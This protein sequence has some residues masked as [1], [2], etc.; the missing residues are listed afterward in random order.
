MAWNRANLRC[1]TYFD[2]LWSTPCFVRMPIAFF[3]FECPFVSVCIR[4]MFVCVHL[5]AQRCVRSCMHEK[6]CA[7]KIC[8]KWFQANT[9]AHVWLRWNS[10]KAFYKRI[11]KYSLVY[12]RVCAFAYVC[13]CLRTLCLHCA[14]V[15]CKNFV[16]F[17]E[18]WVI[19]YLWVRKHIRL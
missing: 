2:F 4:E 6:A 18:W 12:L 3:A 19:D 1:S 17:C 7:L 14:R 10:R 16:C 8:D 11:T 5:Q 9:C 13:A 15:C